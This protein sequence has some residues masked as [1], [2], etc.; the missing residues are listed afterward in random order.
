MQGKRLTALLSALVLVAAVAVLGITAASAGAAQKKGVTITIWDYFDAPP[1]GTAE[2]TAMLA[3]A[4]QWAKKTGNKV[5]DP[6]YVASREDKFVQAAPAGQ[7]PDIIMEAHDRLGSFVVPG[8]LAPA[9]KNLLSPAEKADYSSTSLSAFQYGG[10][11]YG[12]PWAVETYF[13]FYNKDLVKTPPTTWGGVIQT[14]KK[15]TTGDQY[16]FLWDT[17]N[18]YYDFAFMAGYGGYVFKSTKTGLDPN[19]LGIDTPGSI[20]GLKLIQD[21]TNYYKLTPASTNTDVM[22]GKFGSGKAAMIIDGPWAVAGFKAK[23]VNFGVAPLPQFTKGAPMKPFIGVQGFLVNSHSKNTAVAWDLVKYL[24]QH[25]QLA[26][27]KAGGRVPVLKSVANLPLVKKSAV[28][29]AV[30]SSASL[31]VPMPNIP[32]MAAVW[33][34]MANALQTLVQGKSTPSQTAADAQKAIQQAIAQQGG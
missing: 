4:N 13:L 18:F 26:L 32:A 14:A 15:L 9:P 31:G 11:S 24:S 19:Q 22:E 16:G 20:K 25:M 1:N 33:S 2:R 30:S 29:Q 5:V 27:F 3:V 34:P 23:N 10:K 17:T 21:L 8:L 28:T 7:G 12:L 6:G